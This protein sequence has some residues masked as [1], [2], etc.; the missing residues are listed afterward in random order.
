VSL[1]SE[2]ELCALRAESEASMSDTCTVMRPSETRGDAGGITKIYGLQGTL[3]CRVRSGA[4]VSTGAREQLLAARLAGVAIFTV[5]V[6][7]GSDV[8]N[9]DRLIWQGRT[10]EV[11][12]V[13]GSTN[14]TTLPCVCSEVS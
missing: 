5:S 1:L 11:H 12:G 6:P 2:R 13:L 7:V 10:L 3:A 8:R 14:A 4:G 9:D